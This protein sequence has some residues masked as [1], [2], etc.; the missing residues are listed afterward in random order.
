MREDGV[1]DG[2]AVEGGGAAPQL[3]QHHQAGRR[4]VLRGK[5]AAAVSKA[6][7]NMP[8]RVERV[9]ESPAPSGWLL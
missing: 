6:S 9:R 4:R 5:T 1:R 7:W 2:V 8:F 3:V